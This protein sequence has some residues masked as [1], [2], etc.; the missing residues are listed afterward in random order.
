MAGNGRNV[1]HG[2][3]LC[4]C[5]PS[6]ARRPA[7]TETPEALKA[8]M[9]TCRLLPFC[10]ADGPH[11]M[12][13]DEALLASAQ[14]GLASLRF[15]AWSQPT[16]S[17]GYF[18]PARKRSTEGPLAH[19]PFV[20]RPTGGGALVHHH[21]ITYALALP[22]GPPWQGR[23]SWL[24]RMHAIIAAALARLEVQAD[25][26]AVDAAPGFDG[27]LCFLHRTPSDIVIG[28][29]KIVGSAQRKARGALLQHGGLLLA[30][31]PFAPEL[32]GVEELTARR[33][34]PVQTCDQLAACFVEHTGW[35][36]APE[37]WT[38]QEQSRIKELVERK[39]T[40]ESWNWRR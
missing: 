38:P 37:E 39:Y 27:L 10:S 4:S 34:N 12:A 7:G 23:E 14:A 36:V 25:L 22:P 40:S 13:A 30:R 20:R 5:H 29:A 21:E 28:T 3:E 16:V 18:Q 35:T 26:Q 31:S 8:A 19:L 17:L 32:L 24:W 2:F 11:Q 6:A 1:Y 9:T 15:Y 33:L